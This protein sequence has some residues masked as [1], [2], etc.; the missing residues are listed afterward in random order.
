MNNGPKVWNQL[1]AGSPEGSVIMGGAI[2]D[3]MASQYFIGDT[4]PKD[5]DI[6]HTYHVGMPDVSAMW[7]YVP[8]NYNDKVQALLHKMDYGEDKK[9]GSVYNYNVVVPGIFGGNQ[10]VRIQMIGVHYEDPKDHF[11]NFDHTLTLGSYSENGLF[12]HQKVF[13]SLTNKEVTYLRKE[14][15]AG[16]KSWLRAS[17]KVVR[18]NPGNLDSWVFKG[19]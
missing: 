2:V 16:S 3:Y 17:N 4:N 8:M 1:L 13:E 18:Y 14:P 7:E 19:F 12:I 6:F 11:Q 10:I 9:I 15:D 5:F